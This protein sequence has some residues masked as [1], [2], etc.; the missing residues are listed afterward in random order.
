MTSK[1]QRFLDSWKKATKLGRLKYALINAVFFGIL[2]LVFSS[3]ISFYL[4]KE[5]TAF[6]FKRIIIG[7]IT[8]FI[9]GFLL[10]YYTNWK[11]NSTRYNELINKTNFFIC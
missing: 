6:E 2:T 1:D 7:L 9:V 8:F 3:L 4:F 10:Y 5:N 11:K